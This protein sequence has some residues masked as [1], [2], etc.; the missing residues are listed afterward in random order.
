[1]RERGITPIAY[2]SLAPAST[3]RTDPGHNSGK[4]SDHTAHA[5]IVAGMISKYGVSEAQLLL[6]WA[7]QHGY[8]VLPKSSK[9]TRIEENAR[10][11]HF[12]I[13]ATDMATLDSLDQNLA[14][15]WPGTNPVTWD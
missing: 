6:K 8:P 11:F 15:A 1:M 10:L 14:L 5:A 9:A 12:T 7:I 2:S 3:W 4:T 13:D